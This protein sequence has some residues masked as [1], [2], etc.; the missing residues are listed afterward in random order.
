[1]LADSLPPVNVFVGVFSVDS[2]YERRHLIRQTY[3]RHSLPIDPRTG[4]P[5]NNVQLKFI[6]GRPRSNHA[7]RIALEM[8]TFNDL[9]VLDT[10][11]NMNRGKTHAYFTW[12]AENATVPVYYTPP[13]SNS[14]Q[15]ERVGVGFRKADFVV[16]ADDD[17]FLV[18][19][20]LERHLRIAPKDNTYWGC[21]LSIFN[22]FL[23]P[24]F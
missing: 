2:S 3:A 4:K 8:E 24:S 15:V 21:Q 14:G 7:R 22:C 18:L 12:A 11:E 17:S 1:V 13:V 10:R 6:L 19:S 9:V 20:E 23:S 16:K 5:A